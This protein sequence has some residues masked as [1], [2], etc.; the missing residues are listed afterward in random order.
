MRDT[1][2]VVT[3]VQFVHADFFFLSLTLMLTLGTRLASTKV[4]SLT[5]AGAF[6][7]PYFMQLVALL[8]NS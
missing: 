6:W 4:C 1:V 2:V 7:K 3:V 5:V 8:S